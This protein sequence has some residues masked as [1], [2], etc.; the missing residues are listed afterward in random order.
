MESRVDRTPNGSEPVLVVRGDLDLASAPALRAAII[1]AVEPGRDLTI[2]L[3][4]VDLVDSTGIGCLIGALRRVR[5]AGGDVALRDPRPRV[6]DLLE[7]CGLDS[8]F[9]IVSTR[10]VGDRP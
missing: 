10:E 9:T 5:Q 1:G 2:D 3:S 4:A 6:L 7:L 8:V